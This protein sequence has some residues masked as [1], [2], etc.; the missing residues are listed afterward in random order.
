[1]GMAKVTITILGRD[2]EWFCIDPFRGLHGPFRTES[3]A[4]RAAVIR[5][6]ELGPGAT[7]ARGYEGSELFWSFGD[8]QPLYPD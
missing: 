6:E 1:M 4:L 5:V 7:V 3:D 2:D 8:P